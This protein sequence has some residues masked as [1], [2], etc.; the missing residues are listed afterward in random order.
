MA[1]KKK[2][3]EI[4]K[5]EADKPVEVVEEVK[6]DAEESAAVDAIEDA[7]IIE[8]IAPNADEPA[9]EDAESAEIGDTEPVEVEEPAPEGEPEADMDA[10]EALEDEL[11]SDPA[12]EPVLH[13]A[14]TVIRKGGF[15]PMVLGGAVAAAAGF[16]MATY[17]DEWPWPGAGE[18]GFEREI[19]AKL[20]AQ[21]EEIAAV[22]TAI[23]AMPEA[24]DL[25]PIEAKLAGLGKSI[26]TL[27][28][29]LGNVNDQMGQL[30]Q[31]LTDLEKRPITDGA[32]PA[33]VAAYERE[34]KALQEAMAAQRAEIEKIAAEAARS[35]ANAEITAQEAMK[36]AA[37]SQIQTA[38]DTGAG[39]DDAAG[40]L[41]AVGIAL[42]PA[43]ARVAADG[44]ATQAELSASFPEAA[45]AALKV[46]RKE[47]GGGGGLGGFLK[48]QLGARSLEPME[49]ADPDAVLSRAEAA[50]TEGRTRDAMAE[51]EAL[52]EAARAEMSDWL[53]S[54]TLRIEALAAAEALA[55]EMN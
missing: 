2:T 34:L 17:P 33:A 38:L 52:P 53:A 18:S 45:R 42:P 6:A 40:S 50:V 43:L 12:P 32:S 31:R 21:A 48:T 10:E 28:T 44:V 20:E 54:A 26:A 7:E 46:A 51:I 24:P 47:D 5:A 15:V 55:A 14:E 22:K 25:G 9:G 23:P 29:D 30:E 36:R 37:I 19:A 1:R 11:L 4:K 13:T 16:G 49:G 39:F 41:A 8:E 35:E 3:A 27:S